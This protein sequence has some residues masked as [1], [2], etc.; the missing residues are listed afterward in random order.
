MSNKGVYNKMRD[1][2]AKFR[3]LI[4]V[5]YLGAMLGAIGGWYW[6]AW[7]KP[8][9][10]EFVFGHWLKWRVI[11]DLGMFNFL[12]WWGVFP[13]RELDWLKSVELHKGW[14]PAFLAYKHTLYMW[15]LAGAVIA[16]IVAAI[17]VSVV[18]GRE[19]EAQM[20]GT[21]TDNDD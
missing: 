8:D 16:P 13:A 19:K 17:T 20:Q 6:V 1:W 2:K 4:L 5:A 3:I 7:G 10:F 9:G 21:G 15:T 11:D 18:E 14:L 12:V